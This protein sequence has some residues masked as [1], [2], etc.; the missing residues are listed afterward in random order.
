MVPWGPKT[1]ARAARGHVDNPAPAADNDNPEEVTEADAP[2]G[3]GNGS[4]LVID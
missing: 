1:R 2:S 4:G 3:G